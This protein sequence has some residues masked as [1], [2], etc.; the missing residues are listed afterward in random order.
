MLIAVDFETTGLI[1]GNTSDPFAQPGIVQ[2]GMVRLDGKF[3]EISSFKSFVNPEIPAERW[4]PIAIDTHGIKPND[5]ISSPSFATLFNEIAAFA[6]NCKYWIGYNTRFDMDI[7][8]FQLMRYKFE[9]SYPWPRYDVD[10]MSYVTHRLGKQTK[11]GV[12]YNLITGRPMEGAH[13]ALADLRGTIEIARLLVEPTRFDLPPAIAARVETTLRDAARYASFAPSSLD[14]SLIRPWEKAAQGGP[15][16]SIGSAAPILR[17]P[18][19]TP[20]IVD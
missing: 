17:A 2:I 3:N 5:V 6:S 16:G 15:V 7:L 18:W 12:A 13:D 1:R 4:E 20:K 9:R 8:W 11:L 14:T 19:P 10:I